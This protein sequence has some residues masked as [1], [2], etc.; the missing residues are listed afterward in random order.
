[1]VDNALVTD[2]FGI[3]KVYKHNLHMSKSGHWL[4]LERPAFT[5]TSVDE[6]LPVRDAF[7]KTSV[8]SLNGITLAGII[9]GDHRSAIFVNTIHIG[10]P[11]Q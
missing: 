1:M 4:K 6:V 10:C 9:K 7:T 5:K 8:T 2:I 11:N 3:R